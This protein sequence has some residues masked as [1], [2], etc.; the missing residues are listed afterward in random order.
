MVCEYAKQPALSRTRQ[1]LMKKE[2]EKGKD[3]AREKNKKTRIIN[4]LNNPFTKN[5][6]VVGTFVRDEL[7]P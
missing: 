4:I 1:T 2:K 7:T 5:S 3:K 6:G